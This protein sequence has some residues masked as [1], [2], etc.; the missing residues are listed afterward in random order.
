MPALNRIAYFQGRRDELPNQELARDLARQRDR[1]GIREIA[2]NLWNENQNI[3]SDCLKVLYEI[4]Y[5]EP[6]F[7]ADY[8]ADF[9]KLLLSKNN[10]MVWGSMI[11]L[12]TIA[13]IRADAIA[14]HLGEIRRL[15]EQGSVIT[16]VNGVR[17]LAAVASTAEEYRNAIFPHLL[18]QL[19]TCRPKDVP[20]LAESILVAVNASNGDDFARVLE[21]RL[22]DMSQSGATRLRKVIRE[23]ERRA[24]A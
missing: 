6:E 24:V 7:I 14:P 1:Q 3:R 16:R 17:I 5:L 21:S 2:Q 23:A 20:Q 4:G 18:R 13:V 12:S 8:V 11:A 10:R 19:E 9:L 22:P 15:S